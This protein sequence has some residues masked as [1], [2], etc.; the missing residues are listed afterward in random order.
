[1]A[2]FYEK[3]KNNLSY[4]KLNRLGKA[5]H[6]HRKTYQN[7]EDKALSFNIE[8]EKLLKKSFRIHQ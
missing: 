4:Q 1:M 7:A 6:N 5:Y 3:P 8:T 2:S